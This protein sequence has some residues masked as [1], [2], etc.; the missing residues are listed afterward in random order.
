M[1]QEVPP[2]PDLAALLKRPVPDNVYGTL[3]RT[4][5]P[6]ELGRVVPATE[7]YVTH[8]PFVSKGT[9]YFLVLTDTKLYQG[10]CDCITPSPPCL[11]LSPLVFSCAVSDTLAKKRKVWDLKEIRSIT[12]DD[13]HIVLTLVTRVGS[14]DVFVAPFFFLASFRVCM[15]HFS[16]TVTKSRRCSRVNSSLASHSHSS[17]PTGPAS[18]GSSTSSVCLSTLFFFS[19]HSCNT[20]SHF[21]SQ[22]NTT[23]K[24]V[25]APEVYQCH[26]FVAYQE[27]P[28]K[29]TGACVVLSTAAIYVCTLKSGL[30]A[31]V[32]DKFAADKLTALA[33]VPGNDRAVRLTLGDAT[34]VCVAA[35]ADERNA[36]FVPTPFSHT[37]SLFRLSRGNSPQDIRTAA[38][39]VGHAEGQSPCPELLSAWRVSTQHNHCLSIHLKSHT[40]LSC[41]C[42]KKCTETPR[43]LRRS[44]QN[45]STQ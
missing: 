40:P 2:V 24:I 38:S 33:A 20:C 42:Q 35:T 44:R 23:A 34:P 6:A 26:F 10:L 19:S 16:C 36:L 28:K 27:T 15:H 11:E 1:S 43:W 14:D 41:S 45:E 12:G 8:M 17:L 4:F 32:K 3:S 22:Q 7:N 39:R 5:L 25:P 21:L 29:K 30:P 18:C 31:A 13:V 9:N 37:R